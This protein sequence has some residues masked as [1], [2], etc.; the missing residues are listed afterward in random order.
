MRVCVNVWLPY[1]WW[2]DIAVRRRCG[3]YCRKDK[4]E[5]NRR[6]VL[7]TH[8]FTPLTPG[9]W[10]FTIHP[11]NFFCW[12]KSAHFKWST[13][14]VYSYIIGEFFPMFST[15]FSR[16]FSIFHIFLIFFPNV[17]N[18][19]NLIFCHSIT[20]EFHEYS[21]RTPPYIDTYLRIFPNFGKLWK[22]K[23]KTRSPIRMSPNHECCSSSSHDDWL[24]FS[25][26]RPSSVSHLSVHSSFLS[27]W[28]RC[29]F[30]GR[31]SS[32]AW[33]ARAHTRTQLPSRGES[34][35]VGGGGVESWQRK[36][37]TQS[38]LILK[39]KPVEESYS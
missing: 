31:T 25:L 12:P 13:I 8:L 35:K 20:G 15:F 11:A 33:K 29:Q 3:R 36:R 18:L 28:R 22:K 17:W 6:S 26:S 23:R 24:C 1:V 14:I 27:P 34:S 19:T 37:K 5:Q 38:I 30:L 39:K 21:D 32:L 9:N 4:D 7:H 10:T 16:N 2:I